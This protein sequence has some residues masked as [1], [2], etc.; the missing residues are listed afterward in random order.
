M[1]K[2]RILYE[3]YTLEVLLQ[4]PFTLESSSLKGLLV[5]A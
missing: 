3:P 2:L 1:V 5:L 4:S